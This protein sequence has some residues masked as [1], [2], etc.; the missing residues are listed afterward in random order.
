MN[1]LQ[2]IRS[3]CPEEGPVLPGL[4]FLVSGADARVRSVVG[5]DLVG[6]AW[7][8]GMTLLVVDNTHGNF[9]PSTFGRYSVVD[10][11]SGGVCLCRDL[12]N[13]D[14]LL[15]VTRLRSLLTA[16]GFDGIAAMRIVTYMKFVRETQIRLGHGPALTVAVLEEYG[17][18]M[19][20]EWKLQQLVSAGK[21]SGDNYLYLM[22]RYSEVS[23]AA[24]DFENFLV[25]LG[26]FLGGREPGPHSAVHF[27]MGRLTLDGPMQNV[28]AQ[29]LLSYITQTPDQV[30][31]LILDDGKGGQSFL[32]DIL[33]SL[34]AGTEAHMLTADGF[35][36]PDQGRDLL[37]NTFPVRIYS[38]HDNMDSAGAVERLC[39][40]VD[41]VKRSTS[42]TR[43]KRLRGS[44]A[45]DLLLGTN[46]TETE[47]CHAPAREARFRK[48]MIASLPAG[49]AIVDYAG[50]HM[51]LQI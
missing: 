33:R 10:A 44:S 31:V 30:V 37:L 32:P 35:T 49:T 21:L 15:S 7:D 48:E 36:L 42:V 29:L 47:V 12:L 34:P 26:P 40:Q 45:W 3:V 17:S 41:V 50:E 2:V 6:S 43:D 14:S 25:L 51:L 38:R 20:V 27:P 9:S 13:V 39:G 16:L 1:Y 23:G 19:L 24:A 8:R 46:R 11:L 4:R 22:G 28:L 5:A 18:V